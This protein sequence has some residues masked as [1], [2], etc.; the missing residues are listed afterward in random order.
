VVI[1]VLLLLWGLTVLVIARM[2][3]ANRDDEE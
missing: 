1:L 3:A 2:L